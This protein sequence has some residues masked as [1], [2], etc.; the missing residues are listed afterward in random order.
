MTYL[1]TET[2]FSVRKLPKQIE[3]TKI[4]LS[5][6]FCSSDRTCAASFLLPLDGSSASSEGPSPPSPGAAGGAEVGEDGVDDE[7]GELGDK[8]AEAE[9]ASSTRL[10]ISCS[11]SSVGGGT[12]I[13]GGSLVELVDEGVLIKAYVGVA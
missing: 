9:A 1:C 12:G 7:D 11:R 5:R 6:S 2:S 10:L 3:Q 13:G 4:K 8:G